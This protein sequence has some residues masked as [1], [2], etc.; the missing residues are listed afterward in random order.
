MIWYHRP[1][2]LIEI[3]PHMFYSI[4]YFFGGIICFRIKHMVNEVFG[5]FC[6]ISTDR[7]YFGHGYL[8]KSTAFL[9]LTFQIHR[10]MALYV[11]GFWHWNGLK[12]LQQK[13]DEHAIHM[14]L[15]APISKFDETQISLRENHWNCWMVHKCFLMFFQEACNKH[16]I[17]KNKQWNQIYEILVCI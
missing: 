9:I 7:W 14:L 12:L 3:N 10:L 8:L 17:S 11:R 15:N 13:L 16:L 2:I 4:S 6:A 1:K 5:F